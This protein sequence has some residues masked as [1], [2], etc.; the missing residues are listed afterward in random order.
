MRRNR[1]KK[2]RKIII[3]LLLIAVV[4]V[5][6]T[7]AFLQKETGALTNKFKIGEI[8]T[9]IEEDP[10]VNGSTIEKDPKVVNLGPNDCIVRMRAVVSPKEIA[11]FLEDGHINYDTSNWK[12]GDDGFWYYQK[13]VP[14]VADNE[15]ASSTTSLFTEITGLTDADGKIIEQFKDVEDFQITL[16]QEAVQA[17][18]WDKEGDKYSAYNSDRTYNAEMAAKTCSDIW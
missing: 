13:I 10:K 7:L 9:V 12:L 11:D 14:Y 15:N 4:C 2:R 3:P 18:V 17:V 16:Y 1:D 8:T 6:I 5:G